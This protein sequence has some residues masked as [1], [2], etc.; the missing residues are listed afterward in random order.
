MPSPNPS[1]AILSAALLLLAFLATT[2][3]AL[4]PVDPAT[5]PAAHTTLLRS[6]PR[7]SDPRATTTSNYT[8][9]FSDEFESAARSFGAPGASG[10][11]LWDRVD[12]YNPTTA[13]L[14]TYARRQA[15]VEGGKLLIEVSDDIT[16]DPSGTPHPYTSAMLQTWNKTCVRGGVLEI[17]ARLPGRPDR[18]GLWPAL[19]LLGNLKRVGYGAAPPESVAPQAANGMWPWSY[20]DKS[21][22]LNAS[23][24]YFTP[25]N[26]FMKYD[27]CDPA[28]TRP[29]YCTTF[30]YSDE[31]CDVLTRNKALL[32]PDP[33][34]G[35]ASS[36]SS[37]ASASSSS[38]SSRIGRGRGRG[39]G[40]TE[41]DLAEVS[42]G[43]Q[44]DPTTGNTTGKYA[45]VLSTSLQI[46]PTTGENGWISGNGTCY[47][48]VAS[49]I[50][51]G[52]R[53]KVN[54]WHGVPGAEVMSGLTGLDSTAYTEQVV[55][56]LEWI[57]GEEEEEEEENEGNETGREGD[58]HDHDDKEAGAGGGDGG[59]RVAWFM[60]GPTDA[61]FSF[62]FE[63]KQE[64]LAACGAYGSSYRTETRELPSEPSYLLLNVALAHAFSVVPT[65]DADFRS[66]F[67]YVMALDYVRW[68]T[69]AG[70]SQPLACDTPDYPTAAFIDANPEM[71]STPPLANR[72]VGCPPGDCRGS[73]PAFNGSL[74][75][76]RWHLFV[77][78]RC[79]SFG[80]GAPSGCLPVPG[81]C[82]KCFLASTFAQLAF[83]EHGL[84]GDGTPS[85]ATN[86]L[87]ICPPC[88][89]ELAGLPA[90]ECAAQA[91]IGA[92]AAAAGCKVLDGVGGRAARYCP[93]GM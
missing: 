62:L 60:K 9:A 47:D 82:R 53:T 48:I 14:E 81:K 88:V 26:V 25:P 4:S 12:S 89:C 6:T 19:W 11:G 64:A 27:A 23:W 24:P 3:H 38:S 13:D 66:G 33:G 65:H 69:Q 7:S 50:S 20:P 44:V 45:A 63:V 76:Q 10:G 49:N 2:T 86:P 41:L 83:T 54:P 71:F 36:S 85:S 92:A 40:V 72:T 18:P 21:S 51:T 30:N 93:H 15:R 46:A 75:A 55:Y 34:Q 58:D 8:L 39:R 84:Y 56:R 17:S 68:Y 80:E 74:P 73:G 57:L 79:P 16:L 90:K 32:W 1:Q 78:E 70:A 28:T 42:V 35:G 59:G 31:D 77:D 22:C 52:S 37:A 5:P 61:D 87:P 29:A 43:K 67:P 91:L